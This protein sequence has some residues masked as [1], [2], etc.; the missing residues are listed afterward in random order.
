MKRKL[1][2]VV[3]LLAMVLSVVGMGLAAAFSWQPSDAA[4]AAGAPS[5]ASSAP[6]WLKNA[7]IYQVNTRQFS[8]KGDFD[9]VTSAIP[10][11][12]KLGVDVLWLMPIHP[13][14]ELKRKGLLGSPYSV[15]D[16]KAI[17]P[18]LGTAAD[19]RQLV[20]AA[21]DNGMKVIL[22][23][24]ANHS[25]WDNPW[26]TQHK[27]W[28]TQDGSGNVVS[29][30]PDWDDV[31]D[32]NF[33]NNAMRAAMIDALKYWVS[34]FDIDGYRAD[35]AWG[36]PADF[37]N[38]A[39]VALR[40]IKPVFMLAEAQGDASLRE[41]AFVADYG[42]LFKDLI[43]GFGAGTAN[44]GD[45]I[46]YMGQQQLTYQPGTYPMLFVTNHDENSWAG[47]LK[48]M[49]GNGA[50]T[51][52]VL[53]FTLPGIPLIYNGQEVDSNKQ[54]KFFEKDLIDWNLTS[55]RSKTAQAFYTKLVSL[56]TKNASLWNG[57]AGG[58]YARIKNDSNIMLSYS[59]TAKNGNKVI[60]V[61]NPSA[62]PITSKVEFVKDG[63]TYFRYSDATKV[64]F[65]AS[66]V[67]SLKAWGFEVYSTVKP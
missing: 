55:T 10:R 53:T 39:M 26:I 3:V 4:N 32:L 63:K 17:N 49:Y 54:L 20:S 9:S 47:P 34:G 21:H 23:W 43:V 38:S 33:D 52:S 35:V 59:R 37:W 25:S 30:N 22:D 15:K 19:L 24:V 50:K 2:S 27:D 1:V 41:H 46:G 48:T 12:K 11:L 31:A 64:R 8:A 66:K 6:T 36:V 67:V 58:A 28:Y 18:D 65:T 29:P 61:L 7:V 5:A 62:M 16:Y 42:W 13:I 14:G 40:T 51:L 45:F 60:V 56:K 44:K 57:A